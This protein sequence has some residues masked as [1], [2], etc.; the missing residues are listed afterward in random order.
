MNIF[1]GFPSSFGMLFGL[2]AGI[3]HRWGWRGDLFSVCAESRRA[4]SMLLS[5]L[6]SLPA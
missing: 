3:F 6:F 4:G 5:S 2:D 1:D